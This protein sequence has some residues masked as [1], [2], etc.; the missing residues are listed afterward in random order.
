V[1]FQHLEDKCAGKL[2]TWNGKYI[3]MAD[4]ASLIKSVIASQ[5]I[6]YLTPL[7]LPPGTLKFI[8]KL[9]RVFLWSDKDKTSSANCKI[10]WEAV[11]RP[12][13]LGG[14][15]IL[16]MEKFAT[17]LRLCWPW[18]EWKELDK[19][20][21]GSGNPCSI[22]DM[23]IFYAATT[24]TLGN[25][26]KTPFWH[27]PWLDGRKPKDI[28]PLI[29]EASKR[30]NWPVFQALDDNAWIRK[31]C[32]EQ[33]LM[34]NHI[35]QDVNLVANR[36]DDIL[37]KFKESGLYMTK[38]ANNMQF[39]GMIDSNMHNMIWKAWAPSKTKFFA[40]EAIQNRIWMADRLQ[41]REWPNCGSCPLCK[42]AIETVSHLFVNCRFTIRLS[43]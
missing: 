10:N 28:A 26:K 16:H 23:D 37:W 36:D 11:C 6:Y 39:L 14:L 33:L 29:F 12:K 22:K 34:I 13:K 41:K 43:G 40:W 18:L 4:Q 17:A 8:N 7:D 30:K 38:S 3:A 27:A 9:E 35:I 21:V 31:V 19:I 32:L 15:G 42:Q 1:D 2:P 24:I 20:W 5:A 25:G